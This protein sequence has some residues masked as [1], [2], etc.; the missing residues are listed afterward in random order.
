M[1]DK[2]FNNP[3]DIILGEIDKAAYKINCAK[4]GKIQAVNDD[5]SVNV[6][7]E[8]ETV[9]NCLL[10]CYAATSGIIDFEDFVGADCLVIFCDDDLTR[11]KLQNATIKDLDKRKHTLNNAIAIS[12]IFPFGKRPEASKHFV[13]YEQ[14]NDIL[15]D[16]ASKINTFQTNLLNALN[17]AMVAQAPSGSLP[18]TWVSPLPSAVD[19]IDIAQSKIGGIVH[20]D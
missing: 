5:D 4:V 10:F 13:S 15:T 1:N 6:Q 3:E 17:A 12:G 19:A 7:L 16:W 8:D 9:I 11:F 14:L 20:N 2:I 18:I